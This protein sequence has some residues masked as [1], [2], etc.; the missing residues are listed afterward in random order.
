MAEVAGSKP[1][2]GTPSGSGIRT[3]I[4]TLTLGSFGIV[5]VKNTGNWRG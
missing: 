4:P 1:A 5:V 3:F 2:I